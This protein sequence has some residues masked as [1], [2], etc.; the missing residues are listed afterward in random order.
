MITEIIGKIVENIEIREDINIRGMII[1]NV[2]VYPNI[3][4]KVNGMIKGTLTICENASV[5]IDGQVENVINEGKLIV[6]GVIMRKL[7]TKATGDTRLNRGC[8]INGIR[9]M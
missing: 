8:M 3:H 9:Q 2:K 6:N 5:I 1:G 7:E 4:L